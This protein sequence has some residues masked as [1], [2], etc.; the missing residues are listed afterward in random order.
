MKPERWDLVLDVNLISLIQLNETLLPH[1][2]DH[3]RIVCTSSVMGLSGN[4]GQSNYTTSKAGI[5]GY[6]KGLAPSLAARGVCV[7]AVAPG[8]IETKMTDRIPAAVKEVGRRLSNL[9]Q[10]GQP[11]DVAE[12]VAFLSS[13]GAFGITGS[14]VRVCGG[15]FMGA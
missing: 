12:L 8:F 14:V 5:M 15:M 10:G 4:A 3:G 11:E 1:L 2:E 7:N 13:P 6:V 9:T